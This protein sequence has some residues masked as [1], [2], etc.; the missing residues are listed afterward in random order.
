[1]EEWHTMLLGNRRGLKT[2]LR[3]REP[4]PANRGE[5]RETM[6]GAMGV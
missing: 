6:I 1:L 4:L 3:T 2:R 5:G